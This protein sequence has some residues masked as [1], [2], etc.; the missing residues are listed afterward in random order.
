[1][2][3]MEKGVNIG[4]IEI[5]KKVGCNLDPVYEP[6]RAG[7]VRDSLASLER[8]RAL[9]GY[10]PVVDFDTGLQETLEFFLPTL[11]SS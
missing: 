1:M 7:D 11:A 5:S 3:N 6:G 2:Q 10:E 4:L 9:L 8:S